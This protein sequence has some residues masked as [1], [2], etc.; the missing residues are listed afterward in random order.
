MPKLPHNI[1]D[2]MNKYEI[3]DTASIQSTD[4]KITLINNVQSTMVN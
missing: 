4:Q 3:Y 1:L 2:I